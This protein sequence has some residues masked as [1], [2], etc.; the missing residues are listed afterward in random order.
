[1]TLKQ[2]EHSGLGHVFVTNM[3]TDVT[4]I[5]SCTVGKHTKVAE[6]SIPEAETKAE[7]KADNTHGGILQDK[8]F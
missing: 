2:E 4:K 3:E 8:H 1:M 5:N 6:E 7:N